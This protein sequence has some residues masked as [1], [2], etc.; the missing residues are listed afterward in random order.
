MISANGLSSKKIHS[1][2]SSQGHENDNLLHMTQVDKN[3]RK[4]EKL[5]TKE[6]NKVKYK[7]KSMIKNKT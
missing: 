4:K 7:E 2:K 1:K 6:F 3:G 5:T